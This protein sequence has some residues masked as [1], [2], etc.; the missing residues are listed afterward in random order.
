MEIRKIFLALLRSELNNE[1]LDEATKKLLARED[2]RTSL[3]QLSKKYDL[4]HFIAEA[5]EDNGLLSNDEISKK[6]I[7]E[8]QVAVFRDAKMQYVR[9]ELKELFQ[10]NDI[11]FVLL[12]GSVIRDYYPETWMR[13]SCDIDI[14]IHEEDID[15]ALQL[16]KELGYQNEERSYRD[17]SLMDPSGVHV[18]LHFSLKQA[19]DMV[20]AILEKVWD[21]VSVERQLSM[22]FFYFHVIAHMSDHFRRGGCGVRPFVDLCLLDRELK[23]DKTIV[24]ELLV[25]AGIHQFYQVSQKLVNA[26]FGD[27]EMDGPLEGVENYL[28]SAGLYGSLQNMV[29]IGKSRKGGKFQ[30][31]F[32]RLFLSYDVLKEYYPG[33]KG[34]KW[35]TGFYQ[36][37]RWFGLLSKKK[38]SKA[39]AEL[40]TKADQE[41]EAELE[42]V[43]KY[44]GL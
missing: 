30:Y 36:V 39:L 41:K 29:M 2:V 3:Y 44:A 35:L 33:L 19:A 13:T 16:T 14:L 23:L 25:G 20:D 11:A 37:R 24:E 6:F 21:Y 8:R 5:L 43:M 7:Q 32:S 26:W 38:R 31:I 1:G 15:K 42:A 22:E 28:L 17:I 27:G 9:E 40:N 4:A 10:K 12:K 18:E 34:K